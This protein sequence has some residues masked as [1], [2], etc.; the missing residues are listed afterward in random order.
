MSSC[1]RFWSVWF[2]IVTW[3]FACLTFTP[4]PCTVSNQFMTGFC[5]AAD[6]CPAYQQLKQAMANNEIDPSFISSINCSRS[7]TAYFVCCPLNSNYLVPNAGMVDLSKL[8]QQCGLALSDVRI[9]GG[10]KTEIDEFPWLALMFY[11]SDESDELVPKCGGALISEWWVL[12]AAHCITGRDSGKLKMIRFGEHDLDTEKDCNRHEC[13]DPV[14][15]IGVQTTIAHPNYVRT[16]WSKANDLA[17]VKLMRNVSFTDFVRPICLPSYFNDPESKLGIAVELVAS[18]WGYTDY[19]ET[20]TIVSSRVKLKVA[21]PQIQLSQC[22]SIYGEYQVPISEKQICAGGQKAQ[23]T[24]RGDSGSPLMFYDAGR[25]RW[26]AYGIVSRGPSHCG[27]EGIPSV[28]TNLFQYGD[29]I[30]RT[31]ANN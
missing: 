6:K 9:I 12:T 22:Q 7:D 27:T 13:A 31:M 26:F 1:L 16:S 20:D 11:E 2:V 30:R 4:T 23:D 21:L 17:L 24:C 28:Y 14:V 18:G 29:W 10:Q 25:G 19:Y 5:M 8:K 15:D 3:S